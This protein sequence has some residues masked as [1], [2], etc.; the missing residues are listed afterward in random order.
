M[1]PIASSVDSIVRKILQKQH[2]LLPEI[3]LNW[4][5]IVGL[6]FS[7]SSRPVKILNSKEKGNRITVLKVS[8]DNPSLAMEFAYQQE[9]FLERISVY[10]GRACIDKMHII[11]R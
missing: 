9:I 10:L 7:A 1:K 5:K 6:K 11:N 3:L 2:P 4:T 8:V